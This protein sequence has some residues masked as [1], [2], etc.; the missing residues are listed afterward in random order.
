MKDPANVWRPGHLNKFGEKLFDE[1]RERG[2]NL[3]R[4]KV[5]SFNDALLQLNI[6]QTV[7]FSDH[8]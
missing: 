2:S 1:A 6:L 8:I 4:L 7:V 5:D 3:H